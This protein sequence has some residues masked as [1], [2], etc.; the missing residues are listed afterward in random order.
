V[1]QAVGSSCQQANGRGVGMASMSW[2]LDAYVSYISINAY[3]SIAT[4]ML[5]IQGMLQ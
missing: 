1:I 5:L 2:K 3:I 4:F